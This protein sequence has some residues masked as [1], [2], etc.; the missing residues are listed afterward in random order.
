MVSI[1]TA[2]YNRAYILPMLYES[3]K[4]QTLKQFEWIVV[5]DGSVDNTEEMVAEWIK[6]CD[7]FNVRYFKQKNEG[8]VSAFQHG[9]NKAAYE[10]C[11]KIDSDDYL[12]DDAVEMW[13]KWIETIKDDNNFAGVAGLMGYVTT[14]NGTSIGQYPNKKKYS[15]CIDAT[16]LQRRKYKLRGDKNEVYRTELIKKFPHPKF[17]GEKGGFTSVIY[18]AIAYE[19]YKIRWFNKI[20]V[21]CDYS[22]DGITRAST[23]KYMHSFNTYIYATQKRLLYYRYDI[24]NY[25]RVIDKYYSVAEH[26]GFTRK[27]TRKY[28]GISVP[29]DFLFRLLIALKRKLY[30]RP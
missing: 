17:E 22:E 9:V 12:E 27:Q 28:I 18:N 14:N 5:D 20:T 30:K 11:T 15:E 2:T 6:E 3:L 16:N 8:M 29:T 25:L 13:H 24:I 21:R 19:G 7:L 10:W 26:K 1:I 23:P 4:R